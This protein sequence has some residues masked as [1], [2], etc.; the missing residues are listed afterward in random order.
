MKY[1]HL[2]LASNHL[3]QEHILLMQ[4]FFF[5]IIKERNKLNPEQMKCKT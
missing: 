5:S 4:P 3:R 2:N 1:G